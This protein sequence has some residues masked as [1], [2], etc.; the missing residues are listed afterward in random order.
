MYGTIG[1]LPLFSIVEETLNVQEKHPQSRGTR[2]SDIGEKSSFLAR[3]VLFHDL[4][5]HGLQE[6]ER[7]SI[8]TTYS[9]GRILYR[10]GETATALLLLLSGEVH[11]YHLSTDGRKLITATLTSGASFGELPLLSTGIHTS[12]A[13]VVEDARLCII[14]RHDVEHLL[15]QYP[16]ITRNM[17]TTMCQRCSQLETQLTNIAFKSTTAQL[18]TL[19]LQLAGSSNRI[20][21]LSHE[22]LAEHLGVYRETVS[23]ALRELKE[24]G[25]LELGRKH[26]TIQD[27][28]L[29]ETFAP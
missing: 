5:E 1:S 13:E 15:L 27:K 2:T 6:V 14:N 19:L 9:P 23:V 3:H 20:E 24:S 16:G 21:G 17:L 12:F 10:P 25:A 18:A 11:L 7:L 28:A 8:L 29:L 26:V 22:A 4:D